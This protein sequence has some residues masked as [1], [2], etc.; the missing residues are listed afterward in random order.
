MD[1]KKSTLLGEQHTSTDVRKIV[2]Q[3]RTDDKAFYDAEKNIRRVP[4]FTRGPDGEILDVQRW[5]DRATAPIGM[6]RKDAEL[7]AVDYY[8]NGRGW[9]RLGKK[10]ERD[11][12][13][14]RN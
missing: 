10:A 9:I 4:H 8:Q 6:S 5:E 1:E 2:E 13:S 11:Y 7:N 3:W 12:D 14:K